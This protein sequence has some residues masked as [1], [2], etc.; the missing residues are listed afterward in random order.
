MSRI[1]VLRRSIGTAAMQ[2]ELEEL[3]REQWGRQQRLS[4]RHRSDLW[5]PDADVYETESDYVVLLE[6]AG[7]RGVELEITLTDGALFVSGRRPELHHPGAVHFHQLSIN[8]GPFQCA[9]YIPGPV[10]EADVTATYDDGLLAVTLPKR[11]PVNRRIELNHEAS[12][13][14]DSDGKIAE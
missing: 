11:I 12:E 4:M 2:R 7:M 6:L 9:V 3:F 8:E 13:T 5:Q 14:T 10:A 1:I